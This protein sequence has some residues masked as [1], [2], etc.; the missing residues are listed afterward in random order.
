L[1]AGI[2][3][4]G[5]LS[6]RWMPRQLTESSENIYL[7]GK[8]GLIKW[9]VMQSIKLQVVTVSTA[10]AS[11]YPAEKHALLKNSGLWESGRRMAQALPRKRSQ[12][13]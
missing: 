7:N 1:E 8:C 4:A 12:E 6:D 2:K 3:P 13:C 10:A 9:T 5:G 11:R